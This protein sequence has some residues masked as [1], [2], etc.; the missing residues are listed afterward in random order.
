MTG[1]QQPPRQ[2]D[3]ME[4][5]IHDMKR[6]SAVTILL[7]QLDARVT[8][9]EKIWEREARRYFKLVCRVRDEGRDTCKRL[10]SIEERL[11]TLTG[12]VTGFRDF[13]DAFNKRLDALEGNTKGEDK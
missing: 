13:L 6:M 9:R 2:W 11:E 1:T 8:Q 4:E 12:I 7:D 3:T 5:I 10:A